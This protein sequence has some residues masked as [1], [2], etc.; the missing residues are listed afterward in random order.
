V[1]NHC[2]RSIT[3]GCGSHRDCVFC[4]IILLFLRSSVNY[5][6]TSLSLCHILLFSFSAFFSSVS[7]WD[8]FS[9]I[10]WHFYWMTHGVQFTTRQPSCRDVTCL[11][12][13]IWIVTRGCCGA[14]DVWYMWDGGGY[15]GWGGGCVVSHISCCS[16]EDVISP[17]GGR[18]P[19]SFFLGF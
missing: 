3:V 1:L 16:L 18:G 15:S 9:L 5:R 17:S 7:K 14:A 4:F 11:V 10:R 8:A 6:A 19:A 12:S 2:T 13:S